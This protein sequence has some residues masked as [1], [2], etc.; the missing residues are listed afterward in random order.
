M[1][2]IFELKENNKK[3]A[4]ELKELSANIKAIQKEGKYAGLLQYQQRTSKANYRLYHIAYCLLRGRLYEQIEKP[5]EKNALGPEE[6]SFI[7]STKKAYY[8]ENVCLSA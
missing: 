6:W 7:E 8:E 4:A 5:K 1:R 2:K 3:L